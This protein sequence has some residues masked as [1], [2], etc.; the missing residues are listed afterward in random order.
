MSSPCLTL[1]KESSGIM[2]RSDNGRGAPMKS[3]VITLW[4]LLL[5]TVLG[6]LGVIGNSCPVGVGMDR[7]VD[8]LSGLPGILSRRAP[9]ALGGFRAVFVFKILG[10]DLCRMIPSLGG[11]SGRAGDFLM[12]HGEA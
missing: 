9:P 1:D 7:I 2:A 11:G 8:G 10:N 5:S 12:I 6:V 4:I 3:P